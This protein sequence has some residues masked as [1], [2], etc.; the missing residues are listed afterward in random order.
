MD[1]LGKRIKNVTH[2]LKDYIETKLELT[3]LNFGDRVSF[4]IGKSI[5]SLVGY[6]ILTIGLVFAM[7]ALAIYLGELLDEM[8]AGY[9]IVAIPFVVVGLVFVIFKP[10]SIVRSIQDQILAEFINSL[11]EENDLK[12]L[13]SKE[14]SKKERD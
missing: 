8:W 12:E 4:W 9:A 5:Q 13:P 6:T 3:L 10:K 11:D 1:D 2:E 14:I 7:F